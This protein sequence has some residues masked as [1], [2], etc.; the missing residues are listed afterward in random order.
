MQ[1]GCCCPVEQSKEARAAGFDFIECTVVSLQPEADEA[2]FAPILA[3][4]QA[5]ALP[6]RAFNVFLPRDLKV[7]GPEVDWKRVEAYVERA[8][9]RVRL[10]GGQV[11]VFGSG[12][13]RS[14]PDGFA[15]NEAEEQIVRFLRMTSDRAEALDIV[16]AIEPLNR[17]ESNVINSVAEGVE[18]ARR[19]NRPAIRVLADFYHM[20]EEGE[21]LSELEAHGQWLAHIHVADS[22]RLAPGSGN[23]PY[24]DFVRR[25]KGIGYGFA[26][27]QMVSVECRWRDFAAEAPAAVRFLRALWQ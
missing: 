13:A 16:I 10:I 18:F 3:R 14:I 24:A 26:A 1:F 8:L 9:Q 12:G 4:Y 21:P 7:V 23:Y 22:D 25:L 27:N 19:A 2:T 15:R 11:V 6:A 20:D 5:A 17:R